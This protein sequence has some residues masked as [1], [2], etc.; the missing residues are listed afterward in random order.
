MS[1]YNTRLETL[2][3]DYGLGKD[4]RISYL[5]WVRKFTQGRIY[6]VDNNE[7]LL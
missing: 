1:I 6:C 2:D 7:W 4:C 3:L 5:V